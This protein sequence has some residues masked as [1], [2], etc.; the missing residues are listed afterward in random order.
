MELAI[1]GNEPT[2]EVI[3]RMEYN[4]LSAGTNVAVCPTIQQP[5]VSKAL[6]MSS[7]EKLILKPGMDSNLSNV[8][9][10]NPKD[11]PDIIGS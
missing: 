3:S 1:K 5:T 4:I 10:V 11:R 7:E 8:P 2:V 6:V 9:P